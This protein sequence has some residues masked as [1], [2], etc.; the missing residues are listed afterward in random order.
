MST[1]RS[2]VVCAAVN[3][4]SPDRPV[5]VVTCEHGGN[6]IPAELQ[7]R[8][9]TTRAKRAL[10]SHRG[11]DPGAL[12]TAQCFAELTPNVHWVTVSRLVID[13][14]R[15]LDNESLFSKFMRDLDEEAKLE[16]IAKHYAPHRDSVTREI[17]DAI[18]QGKRVIHIGVH[19]FTP[20][21]AG[22]SRAIDIGGLY[23]PSRAAEK[24]F[25]DDWL[26]RIQAASPRLRV[27]HN[28]PYQGTDDGLTTSLRQQFTDDQYAGIELEISQSI[29][30]RPARLA[31]LNPILVTTLAACIET[32]VR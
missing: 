15:S 27:R 12:A 9:V 2:P 22:V 23:D 21:F 24:S 30:R 13:L 7:S 10:A 29:S 25:C 32:R 11:Y 20:V 19:S 6:D 3:H 16:L 17:A 18:F 5:L 4:L 28:A 14:N 31:A 8:F 26:Q 1:P